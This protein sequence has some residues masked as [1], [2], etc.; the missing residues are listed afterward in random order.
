MDVHAEAE[1]VGSREAFVHFLEFLLEDNR[2]RK[3]SWPNRDLESFLDGLT[4]WAGDAVGYY[5]GRGEPISSVDPW[6]FVAMAL[7]AAKY[8]E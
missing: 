1:N 4:A 8:Y 3:E 2:L 7:V 6:R 5:E